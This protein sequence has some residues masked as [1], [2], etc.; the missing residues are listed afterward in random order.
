MGAQNNSKTGIIVGINKQKTGTKYDGTDSSAVYNILIYGYD[1]NTQKWEF[2]KATVNEISVIKAVGSGRLNLKNASV[3]EK[4]QLVGT[5]G[6]L[7]RFVVNNSTGFKPFVILSELRASNNDRLIGY[8]LAT[9]DFK[10]RSIKLS[11]VIETCSRITNHS[12]KSGLSLVPIQNAMFVEATDNIAAHIKGYQE[13]QFIVEKLTINKPE[14]VNPAKVN[15]SSNS[16]KLSKLDELF[17]KDQ[18]NEL[19]LG[20]QS[21]VNIKIYGNNKL[22]AQQMR[23]IRKALEDG[24]NPIP[25]ADPSFKPDT[26]QAYRTQLKYGID[27]SQFINPQYTPAQIY[28]LSTAVLTGVD[29][30]KLADPNKSANQMAKERIEMET[31]IWKEQVVSVVAIIDEFDK[32]SNKG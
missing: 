31:E 7:D 17:T 4:G 11:D 9:H 27:I 26:M 3:N 8:R 12:K 14:N 23:E 10:V 19:R 6:S 21:G 25:F 22:S 28:E 32:K 13:Q 24:L 20:K 2:N 5:T 18:I 1:S 30:A 29:L 16:N 15:Q